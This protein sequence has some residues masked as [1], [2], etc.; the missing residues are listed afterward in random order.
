MSRFLVCVLIGVNLLLTL[1]T[2][3]VFAATEASPGEG[4]SSNMTTN[5]IETIEDFEAQKM[6]S[7]LPRQPG[8]RTSSTE[9]PSVMR[10][11]SSRS[12]CRKR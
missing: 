4:L 6:P 3:R 7:A 12:I 8:L 11:G 10:P 9:P 2:A 1:G 5:I